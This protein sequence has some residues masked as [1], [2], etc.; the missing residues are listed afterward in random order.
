MH[1]ENFVPQN[2]DLGF[3]FC[4]NIKKIRYINFHDSEITTI[5]HENINIS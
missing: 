3:L 1:L 4:S 5:D 2:L